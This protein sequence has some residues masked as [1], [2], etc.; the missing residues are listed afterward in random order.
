MIGVV[1]AFVWDVFGDGFG[2]NDGKAERQ[3][4]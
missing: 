3:L 2:I 1:G 4:N